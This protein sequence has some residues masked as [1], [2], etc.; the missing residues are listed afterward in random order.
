LLGLEG[1]LDRW[2]VTSNAYYGYIVVE[3]AAGFHERLPASEI[4][5]FDGQWP[6][7]LS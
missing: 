2:A 4:A 6:D 3:P 1:F 5:R 7:V